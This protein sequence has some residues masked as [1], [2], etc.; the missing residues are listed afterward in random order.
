MENKTNDVSKKKGQ[1]NET[2]PVIGSIIVILVVLVGGIYFWGSKIAK[3]NQ[4][5]GA[6][7]EAMSASA[8]INSL[9]N[10]VN[11]KDLDNQ[12]KEMDKLDRDIQNIVIQ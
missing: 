3:N 6:E 12:D 10:I 1:Q 9:D 2:G 11:I 7:N 5:A 4:T 8:D